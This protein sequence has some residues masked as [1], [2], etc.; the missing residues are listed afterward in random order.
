VADAITA[1]ARGKDGVSGVLDEIRTCND[2]L[3]PHQVVNDMKP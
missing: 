1:P 2:A 3:S